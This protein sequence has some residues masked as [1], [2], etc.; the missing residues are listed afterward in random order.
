MHRVD[1]LQIITLGEPPSRWHSLNDVEPEIPRRGQK[2][3][4]GE[5]GRVPEA[6]NLGENLQGTHTQVQPLWEE[7]CKL[8]Y[9]FAEGIKTERQGPP[10]QSEIGL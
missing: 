9:K 8:Q 1:L 7:G 5:A 3:A 10:K 2:T 6:P 4:W